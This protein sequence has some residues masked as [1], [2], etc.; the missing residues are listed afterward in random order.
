MKSYF[1][2]NPDHLTKIQ[3]SKRLLLHSVGET[4]EATGRHHGQW[5]ES[6]G[7]HYN[8][9]DF[10]PILPTRSRRHKELILLTCGNANSSH[11]VGSVG[12]V[13]AGFNGIEVLFWRCSDFKGVRQS[14]LVLPSSFLSGQLLQTVAENSNLVAT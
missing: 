2:S 13:R 10:D 11:R 12:V 3:W 5:Q 7:L 14:F 9:L 6:L 1:C 8:A 4:E